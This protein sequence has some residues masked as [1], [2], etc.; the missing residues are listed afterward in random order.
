MPAA[1]CALAAA[2]A[3]S[4]PVWDTEHRVYVAV[5]TGDGAYAATGVEQRAVA[6]SGHAVFV[7][8]EWGV[9]GL[10]LLP[11]PSATGGRVASLDAGWEYARTFVADRDFRLGAALAFG[12]TAWH[13][14]ET[15]RSEMTL[16]LRPTAPTERDAFGATA[17][18]RLDLR[19]DWLVLGVGVRRRVAAPVARQSR[20]RAADTTVI[21]EADLSLGSLL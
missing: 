11:S 9:D 13:L 10:V 19:L 16:E 21:V 20:S 4:G 15:S 5:G 12:A 14:S 17:S 1:L 2:C 7:R 6:P 3:L 18:A 8:A